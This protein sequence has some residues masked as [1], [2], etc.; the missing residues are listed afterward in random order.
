MGS[1]LQ[2]VNRNMMLVQ[3]VSSNEGQI[4]VKRGYS[5]VIEKLPFQVVTGVSKFFQFFGHNR[6]L[7]KYQHNY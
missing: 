3:Q 7:R 6:L 2:G 5:K 1:N 4:K